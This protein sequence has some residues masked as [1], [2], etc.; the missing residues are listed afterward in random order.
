M[1]ATNR[2]LTHWLRAIPFMI[3]GRSADGVNAP[4]VVDLIW[5]KVRRG[6][7]PHARR[8]GKH[9]S[10][11]TLPLVYSC[12]GCSNAAQLA[13]HVAVQ[14][15]RQQLA[16]MSCIAGVGGD[17]ESLVKLAQSGRPI[18]ALDGCSLHCARNCLSRHGVQPTLHYTLS[19]LGVRKRYHA[20][21][22][23][24][25]AAQ[26]FEV[27]RQDLASGKA[28]AAELQAIVDER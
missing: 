15:D 22:T 13:N 12:S 27:I 23:S 26:V 18:V 14:L 5:I 28:Q 2:C 21:F 11:V 6:G 10:Y 19:D 4:W 16:Q 20:E 8:M 17:V 9:T 1:L 24:E 25:E 7:D 3:S